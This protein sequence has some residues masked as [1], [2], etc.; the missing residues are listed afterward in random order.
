M[1]TKLELLALV[2]SGKLSAEEYMAQEPATPKAAG[3]ITLKVSAK[4][5]V[6]LYG[7]G[8]WPVT[9]YGEQWDRVLGMADDIR[10]FIDTN[11]AH[12]STKASSDASKA[13]RAAIAAADAAQ[14]AAENTSPFMA[15]S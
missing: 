11:K 5:A 1:A 14:A 4:G 13:N 3:R 7:L 2:A 12:L 15:K 8:Q 10:T 9:L 6:S